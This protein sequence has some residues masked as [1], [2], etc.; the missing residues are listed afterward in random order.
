MPRIPTCGTHAAANAPAPTE[1][2]TGPAG[3]AAPPAVTT[4]MGS[5]I[6]RQSDRE[7]AR[8]ARRREL[9][10]AGMCLQ[11]CGRR[12]AKGSNLC[13][14]CDEAL[15]AAYFARIGERRP[16]PNGTAAHPRNAAE[17]SR[18]TR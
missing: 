15:C 1:R 13:R 10:D 8:R 11:D 9:F 18:R 3:N 6:R 4:T 5:A 12:A 2:E 17:G 7:R 16:G 14:E